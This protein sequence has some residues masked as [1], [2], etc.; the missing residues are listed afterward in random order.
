VFLR[1][2]GI[3]KLFTDPKDM[4]RMEAFSMFLATTNSIMMKVKLSMNEVQGYEGLM[5]DII[6]TCLDKYENHVY[7]KPTEK[8]VLV[9]VSQKHV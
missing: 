8:H 6:N 5:C 7:L 4:T 1:A 2:A 9:K 3:L